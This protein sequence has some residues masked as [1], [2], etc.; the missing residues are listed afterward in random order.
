MNEQAIVNPDEL[1]QFAANLATFNSILDDASS[2]LTAQFS[3]L[4]ETWRDREHI[5]FTQEFAQ[6]MTAIKRFR[7]ASDEHIPFLIRKAE[8]ADEYLRRR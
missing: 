2:T 6:T 7:E 5:K 8:A 1:R 3:E 4:G